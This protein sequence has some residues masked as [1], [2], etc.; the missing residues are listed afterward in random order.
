MIFLF[1]SFHCVQK[2]LLW[3]YYNIP[4]GSRVFILTVKE[5]LL[6]VSLTLGY[7]VIAVSGLVL[8]VDQ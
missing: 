5:F 8:W 1:D 2:S 7:R 3:I 6:S 4:Y